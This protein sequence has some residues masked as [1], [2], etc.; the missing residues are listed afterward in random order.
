MNSGKLLDDFDV[1]SAIVVAQ[2]TLE[3]NNFSFICETYRSAFRSLVCV[4][5]CGSLG[6]PPASPS[7]G[8]PIG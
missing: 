3:K 2:I 6:G 1:I 8:L 7:L 4:W 5:I